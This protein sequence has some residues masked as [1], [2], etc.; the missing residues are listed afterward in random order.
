MTDQALPFPNPG[1]V[2]PA[3]PSP[4]ARLGDDPAGHARP[5]LDQLLRSPGA[6][7]ARLD[8]PDA[9]RCLVQ[10]ALLALVGHAA[11]GLVVGSFSGGV[12]W[13][14]APL[15]ITLGTFL[16]GA[17]CFPSLYIFV[18]Q[19]A[20]ETHARHVLGMLL[21]MLASTAVLL[22]GFAPVA[23]IFSQ[24]SSTVSLLAP[25]H[26]LVWIVSLVASVRFLKAGLRRWNARRGA[27]TGLWMAI[28]VVTCLQ[29]TTSL[30][31][32]LGTKERLFDPERKLFLLH[33]GQTIW[34]E[35]GWDQPR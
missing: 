2:P 34:W 23:W 1:P 25:L 20:A 26:Y 4:A 19:S 12:Q 35:A 30:R 3:I 21:G 32:I 33:W 29:M 9:G 24:S 27:L 18:S 13:W 6:L 10:L 14:A 7:L 5:L 15:K 17:I 8:G 28:F 22:A 16:C 31:P 11:Y